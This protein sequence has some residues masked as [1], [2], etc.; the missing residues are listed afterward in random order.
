[1]IVMDQN[2]AILPLI[3]I[4]LT[5]YNAEGTIERA[6]RSALAQTWTPLEII[7]VNDCSTD[8]T[9][10]I[11]DTLAQRHPELRVF[12]HAENKGVAATRNTIIHNAKGIFLAFFDDDDQSEPRRLEKQYIRIVSYEEKYAGQSEVICHSARLQTYPD[13][14]EHY[15]ITAG[16]NEE[17]LSPRGEAMAKRILFG[18]PLENGFGSMASCAQMARLKTYQALNGFDENFRRCEDTEFNVRFALNGGHFVGIP[19]PLVRQTMTI[20]SEKTLS[21]EETYHR[22]IIIK[23]A[24]FIRNSGVSPLFCARWLEAKHEYLKGRKISFLLKMA[25]L[26]FKYPRLS[27][28]RIKWAWPNRKFNQQAQAF[29]RTFS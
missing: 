24:I 28:K 14:R 19:E 6:V 26:L 8:K 20:G 11:L 7:A 10:E 29:Y 2:T 23:H 1:M 18:L 9:G 17:G 3:T 16:C 27:Y 13:G 25:R 15:E 5:A 21:A 12:H 22:N 4:G